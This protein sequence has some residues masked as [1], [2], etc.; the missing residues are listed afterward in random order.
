MEK[1][2]V[3][4]ENERKHPKSTN[5]DEEGKRVGHSSAREITDDW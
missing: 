1:H 2:A 3:Y 4:T 5:S